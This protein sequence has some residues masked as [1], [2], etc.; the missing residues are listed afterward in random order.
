LRD[1]ED[2][3]L[4]VILAIPLAAEPSLTTMVEA[5]LANGRQSRSADALVKLIF[6]HFACDSVVRDL[7]DLA[8]RVAEHLLGLNRS[9]E[10]VVADRSRYSTEAVSYAFGLRRFSMDDFPASAYHGPYLRMLWHH[11][12]R[13][14]DFIIRLINRAC[15][16][17]AHPDNRYEY[18]EPPEVVTI[19][20]P[21]GIHEQYANGRLWG[22][23]R[24]ISV[25][26]ECFQSALMALEYW[27]LG[28]NGTQKA[29]KE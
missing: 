7:P 15:E 14:V 22:A 5:T 17:Y 16:A 20:L 1:G 10:E 8:F 24:G 9:L 28:S 6:N 19:Q 27:G 2:R 12:S 13:G 11:P 29:V 23:Y 26:P 4:R 21:D 18:I 3:L 25:A